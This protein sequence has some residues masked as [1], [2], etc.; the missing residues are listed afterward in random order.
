M[1]IA[2]W[3]SDKE[4]L[5]ITFGS[6]GGGE[7]A[8]RKVDEPCGFRRSLPVSARKRAR[9]GQTRAII[10]VSAADDARSKTEM[11]QNPIM[12]PDSSCAASR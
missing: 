8:C 1:N 7:I 4:G 2:Q 12:R 11:Q 9:R 5:A 3:Y 10:G 6:W